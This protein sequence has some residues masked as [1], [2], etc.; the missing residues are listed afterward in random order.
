L[1]SLEQILG[2]G[3]HLFVDNDTNIT[4]VILSGECNPRVDFAVVVSENFEVHI[5]IFGKPLNANH[6]LLNSVPSNFDSITSIERLLDLLSQARLCCG[7]SEN[8]RCTTT[9]NYNVD[10]LKSIECWLT[11]I[12]ATEVFRCR[13]STVLRK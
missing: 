10:S 2:V 4:F 1:P 13:V 3:H 11:S 9:I 6:E 8:D 7:A 12:Q 5:N